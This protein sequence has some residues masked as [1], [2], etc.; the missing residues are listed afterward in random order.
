MGVL[1][2]YPIGLAAAMGHNFYFTFT[3]CGAAAVGGLALGWQAALAAVFVAG[4]LF[5]FL[6]FI[7][8]RELLLNC[9]PLP[10]K[11]GIAAGIGLFI[12]FIGLQWSG[13]VV[14]APGTLVKLGELHS[15]PVLLS[16][17]GILVIAFLLSIRLKGGILFGILLTITLGIP[18]GI[19]QYHGIASM[20]P[21][22]EPTFFKLDFV[23]LFTHKHFIEVILVFL[24]LNLFDTVGTLIGVTKQ[25]GFLDKEGKL[26]RGN[27]ALQADASSAVIGSVLGCSTVTSYIESSAGVTAGGRTGLANMFTA[28]LFLLAIF[29]HPLVQAVGEGVKTDS[30]AVLYPAIAPAL[31]I[32]GSFMIRHLKDIDW[33]DIT[34]SIPAFLAAI[35]MPFTFSITEGISWGIISYCFLKLVSGKYKDV[36]WIIYLFAVIFILRYIFLVF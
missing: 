20:P 19:I 3:V 12:G 8:L 34:D 2:N 24:L 15:P 35:A 13:L 10:L 25:A 28:F 6:T 5:L 22:I 4:I 14:S 26:P 18:L 9:V 7:G 30:G 27:K 16:V 21:S 33:D 29:F 31:I 32:V 23:A 36:H 1:A 17:F 11:S